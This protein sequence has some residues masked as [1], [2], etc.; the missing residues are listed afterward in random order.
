MR[1]ANWIISAALILAPAYGLDHK[2]PQDQ[3]Q[4]KNEAPAT[5]APQATDAEDRIDRKQSREKRRDKEIDQR[6]KMRS[7]DP[8]PRPPSPVR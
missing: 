4:K 7:T 1:F 6:L 5:G 3:K 2:P 8:R